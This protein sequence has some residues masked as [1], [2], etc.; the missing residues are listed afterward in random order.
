MRRVHLAVG[1]LAVAAFLATGQ[2]MRMHMPPMAV[3][4]DGLRMV[5]RSRH[6]YLLGSGLV[7]LLLGL[8]LRARA[9]GWRK[10]TQTAGSVLLLVAPLLLLM[11]FINEPGR[12]VGAE[13]W[14]SSYGMFA[15]FGGSMLHA[16]AGIGRPAEKPEAKAAGAG[17]AA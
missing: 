13:L 1:I 3:L 2:F 8:Y 4:E 15:L 14:Q 16:I 6:I 10:R 11:A 17:R 5:Y 9:A 7:N 12:G